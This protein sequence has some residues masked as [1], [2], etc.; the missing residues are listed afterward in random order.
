MQHQKAER[1]VEVV[2]AAT[3]LRPDQVEAALSYWADNRQE[4]DSLI[5]RI[6]AAQDEAYAAWQRLR[7]LNSVA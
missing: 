5:A 3:G 1:S 2:A 6:Q 4:I 7:D